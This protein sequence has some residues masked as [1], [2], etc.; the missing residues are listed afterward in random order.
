MR[1]PCGFGANLDLVVC[2]LILSH[3]HIQLLEPA[4]A[5]AGVCGD[6]GQLLVA[7]EVA[8]A[9]STIALLGGRPVGAG[10]RGIIHLHAH[11]HTY[12]RGQSASPLNA[13]MGWPA[14]V[15]PDLSGVCVTVCGMAIPC[16]FAQSLCPTCVQSSSAGAPAVCL[17]LSWVGVAG[18]SNTSSSMREPLCTSCAAKADGL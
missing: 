11:T 1:S 16:C 12:T 3:V 2:P 15:S 13:R 7:S 18:S 10:L 9:F 8:K 17:R 4:C 14:L 5:A 6:G